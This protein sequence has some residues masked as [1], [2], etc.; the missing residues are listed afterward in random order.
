MDSD[1]AGTAGE[2]SGDPARRPALARAESRPATLVLIALAMIAPISTDMFIPS[3]PAMAREL[4]SSTST[5]SLAV[6]LFILSFAVAQLFWGPASDR[7]GRRPVLLAGL[8]LYSAGSAVV[9][10]TSSINL[11]VAGR[12]VQGVGGGAAYA[13]S[14]A[15][16]I[17]V[18][19]RV[20][21][22]G[23]LA[24]LASVTG[25]APM[26][27]PTIGG[28]L[29]SAFGWRSVFVV[30]LAFGLALSIGYA[31]IIPE[32]NT[33]R[34]GRA[35]SVPALGRNWATLFR[36]RAYR[37]NVALI[38]VLFCGQFVFISS[39]SFVFIDDLGLSPRLFG[40][41][42]GL[43]ALGMVLGANTTRRAGDRWD[44]PRAVRLATLSAAG[45]ATGMALAALAGARGPW[46]ILGP[47]FVFAY[48][49]GLIRP[50]AQAAAL[51]PF[52]AMA[53][54]ASAVLGFT[55][56]AASSLVSVAFNGI[57]TPGPVTM[58]VVIA[59]A[60]LG[61]VALAW[62]P[63]ERASVAQAAPAAAAPVEPGPPGS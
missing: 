44:R 12:V 48:A 16:V 42:F 40:L 3:M 52:R 51:I 56:L 62:S 26:L 25:V 20:R 49:S 55:Q 59:A 37:S 22:M 60:A 19:G 57:L 46:L 5:V 43:V 1:R 7:F 10:L 18:Y 13:V 47:M 17:D 21:S 31:L 4:N 61:G 32:T 41:G 36:D 15:I 45:A 6:T 63:S 14:Y 39:S 30:F 9:L 2:G 28:L 24:L 8:A 38:T 50:M 58:T 11:V 53:G 23:I 29:Q 33:S 54:L 27:A 35:L 34:D